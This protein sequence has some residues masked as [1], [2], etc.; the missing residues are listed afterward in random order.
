MTK[1]KSHLVFPILVLGRLAGLALWAA[2]VTAPALAQG[3]SYLVFN[4]ENPQL[5]DDVGVFVR[6]VAPTTGGTVRCPEFQR[7]ITAS[8]RTNNE[9]T[10]YLFPVSLPGGF[11]VPVCDGNLFSLGQ[12]PAG[13]YNI[14]AFFRFPNGNLSPVVASGPIIVGAASQVVAIPAAG[15]LA[16]AML[17]LSLGARGAWRAYQ[18]PLRRSSGSDG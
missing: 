8:V 4:P 15:T 6:S 10:L 13:M 5:N 14:K 9:I 11:N 18:A 3:V 12:L 17:I 2:L 7:I 1:S 16:L